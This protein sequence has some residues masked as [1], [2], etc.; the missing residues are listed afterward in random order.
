MPYEQNRKPVG[1][2]AG[3]YERASGT[4]ICG[5]FDEIM[6]HRLVA[7]GRVRFFPMCDYVG[8]RRFRSLLS[9][10][11]T[12]VDVRRTARRRFGEG[13]DPRHTRGHAGFLGQPSRRHRPN[14][15]IR[16][17]QMVGRR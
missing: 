13:D 10:D 14:P 11:V 5:Y 16:G 6:R 4:E 15:F 12:E 17:W 7:S 2:E 9:G 3:F 1:S 8:E